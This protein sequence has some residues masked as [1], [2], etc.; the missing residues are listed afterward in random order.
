MD[1]DTIAILVASAFFGLLF[2]GIGLG[3]YY[4]VKDN[5]IDPKK[6]AKRNKT[7]ADFKFNDFIEAITKLYPLAKR[8]TN[9][10]IELVFNDK[11]SN[12]IEEIGHF[13][14]YIKD[15]IVTTKNSVGTVKLHNYIISVGFSIKPNASFS[16][17][18][19][20]INTLNIEYC[21]DTLHYLKTKVMQTQLYI[22]AIDVNKIK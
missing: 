2:L 22:D 16:L 3:I 9:N 19:D 7:I 1:D 4:K 21:I 15:N 14:Y 10:E 5:F 6:K 13:I 8:E 11:I 17:E 18:S 20:N 12:G